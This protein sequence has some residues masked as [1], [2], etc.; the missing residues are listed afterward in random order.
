MMTRAWAA[1]CISLIASAAIAQTP[2]RV[3]DTPETQIYNL[4]QRVNALESQVV[5]LRS[6]LDAKTPTRVTA[7]FEVV[8]RAGRPIVQVIENGTFGRSLIV[9]NPAGG[10]SVIT[11]DALIIQQQ[12]TQMGVHLYASS[13]GGRLQLSDEQGRA[14][15]VADNDGSSPSFSLERTSKTLVSLDERGVRY[16][17]GTGSVVALLGAARDGSGTVIV[18]NADGKSAIEMHYNQDPVIAMFHPDGT[19]AGYFGGNGVLIYNKTGGAVAQLGF[20]NGGDGQLNLFANS[21]A[22][23]LEAGTLSS[24]GTGIVRVGPHY[25]CTASMGGPTAGIVALPDCIKGRTGQ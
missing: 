7:P 8:D 2:S 23:V 14:Y 9:K 19:N 22:H 24:D 18:G 5:A 21:G 6:Q 25:K 20:G 12:N 13:G 15:L 4:I 1:L 17:N 3:P 10:G 11:H 16:R